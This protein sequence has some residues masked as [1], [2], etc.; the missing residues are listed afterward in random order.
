MVAGRGATGSE[1]RDALLTTRGPVAMLH[2][3]PYRRDDPALILQLA[4]TKPGGRLRR[5]AARRTPTRELRRC[6]LI[7]Q[8]M[9]GLADERPE[10]SGA[11]RSG[12]P[13]LY[14]IIVTYKRPQGLADALR[15]VLAQERPPDLVVV[16]DNE[17]SLAVSR[18]VEAVERRH[19]GKVVLLRAPENLGPAGGTALGMEHI[20]RVAHDDDWITRSDDDRTEK[21]EVY[22][23]LLRFAIE[24]RTADKRVGAVGAVG[25]RFDWRRGRLVRVTDE[26][27]ALGPVDVDYV[28]T[29]VFPAFNVGA[30]RDVG[31]FDVD[32]FYGSSEVEYGLRLRRA[33]YRIVANPILWTQLGRQ[34]ALTA[35]P[36]V[37]LRPFTW[38]RYYS[39][40]NQIYLLRRSGHA[41]TAVRV[42]VVRGLLKP[43][44]NLPRAPRQ[45]WLHLRWNARAVADGW[46]GRMG[47]TYDPEEFPGGGLGDPQAD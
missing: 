27:I 4:R 32:L 2:L 7:V 33:G 46:R 22:A 38:R 24:Q 42:A 35:G 44:L 5:M 10:D 28:P 36:R 1:V 14:C 39:L 20:L 45:A 40:R 12:S 41:T 21:F 18:Q 30:V 9:A 31:V 3:S 34:S 16:V 25:A 47:R 17:G 15:F 13:R 6:H 11:P 19:P 29:G 26:E 8:P 23:E 43:L 37:T